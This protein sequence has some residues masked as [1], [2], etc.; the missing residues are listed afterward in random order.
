MEPENAKPVTTVK[1]KRT[2]LSKLLRILAWIIGSVIFLV[3]LVLLL[4]QLPAV[5]NYG[6]KKVVSFLE[7]KL[8]TKVAIGKL[9]IDF[10]TSLS[11]QQ[12][13]FE[14]QAKDTLL[15]GGELKVNLKML[16]LLRNDIS[17]E[18]IYLDNI[19]ANVTRLPPDS[20]FNFQFIV[21]AFSS[22]QV[23]NPET[24][25]TATLKMA[26]DH[27]NVRNSHIVYK[28]AFTGNDMKLSI[29]SL[30]TD[31]DR[32]DPAHMLF[33]IPSI[34]LNGLT[35]HF[36]QLEPLKKSIEKTVNEAAAE[37]DNFLQ[38][39]SKEIALASIDV[40][41][42]NEPSHL[43]TAFKIGSLN[44]QPET[45][46]LK[47][48][49]IRLKEAALKNSHVTIETDS[50][51][52]DEEPKD[53]VITVETTPPFKIIASKINIE[54][55]RLDF[56]DRAAPR[57]P[58]GMD[59]AH[60]HLSDLSLEAS[61]ILYSVDTITA[62]IAG[63]QMRDQSGFVLNEMRTN[64]EMNPTGVSLQNLLIKTPGSHI[65]R[66]ATI[67]YP[68]L[69]ALQ[70][71]PGVLG[72]DIDLANSRISVKDLMTFVP[73]LQ[74]QLTGLSPDASLYADARITG[75]VN[76]MNFRKLVL[77]GLSGTDI[78]VSGL[79][80]GMPVMEKLYT[81]LEIT[82]LQTNATDVNAFLPK[83]TLPANITL[84]RLMSMT[85][86]IR[87]GMQNMY[88]DLAINS[89]LGGAK[90]AGTLANITNEKNARYDLVVNA[91]NLQLK[92]LL[93]NPQLGILTAD[94]AVKGSGISPESANA[95]FNATV[96]LVTLNSYNYRNIRANGSIANKLYKINA[97]VLDPNVSAS[98]Q[99]AGQFEGD[100]P[101]VHVNAVIDSIK[102]LPLH[103]TA[104]DIKYHGNIVADFAS[105]DP[106]NLRG[107][108][109]V[110]NSILVRNGERVTLDS[111]QVIA[112]NDMEQRSLSLRTGFLG[113]TIKGQYTLTQ[114][115]SVFQQ[116]ID[117]YFSITDIKDTVH[118]AP[119]NF[120]LE[121]KA[122]NDPALRVFVPSLTEMKP[123][124]L[125]ANFASDSGWNMQ[126]NAPKIVYGGLQLDD[127]VFDAETSDSGLAFKT[128]LEQLTSN[129]SP[130]LYI[131]GI[132]GVLNNNRADFVLNIKDKE[133][134]DKYRI[135]AFVAQT[136]QEKYQFSLDPG[137]LLLNYDQWKIN[138]GNSIQYAQNYLRAN[139]FVLSQGEQRLSINSTESGAASPLLVDFKNFSIATLSGFI[140]QDS[141]LVNGLLNGNAL[142]KNIM[143]QPEFITDLTVQD[144]SIYNDTIGNLVAKVDN[145]TANTYR[146]Q[147]NLTGR[148]NDIDIS[149]D[150]VVKPGNSQYDILVAIKSFQ[151]K[152]L[153][154][155][156]NGAVRDGRGNLYGTVALKGTMDEPEIDGKIQFNNT[157]F[158]VSMLNNVFRIDNEAI[159]IIDNQGIRLNTFTIR[160]TAENKLVIDG[161]INT[162]NFMDYSFDLDIRANKFQAINSS[163]KDNELFYGKMV[164]TT[165]LKVTGTP[166]SPV[167][168]G[169][170]TINDETNFTVVLPQDEPGIAQREGIVRFVDY[171]ATAEDS[172]FMAAYDS[173]NVSKLIGY[174][175]AVNINVDKEAVFNLIVDAGNGDFLR[176][177]GTAQLTGGIDPSGKVNLVGSYEIDEGSYDLS[178]N[179]IKRKFS[180]QKGSRIVWTGEPTSAQIDVTAIYQA[181]TAPLDLVQGQISGNE[182]IYK[183]KLPFEV[184]LMMKGELM[185]PVIT[186]DIVLPEEK[187]YNVS[188]D[189]ISTV[190]NKLVQLRQESG[191]MNKQVFALLLLNRFVGANP[192]DNSSGGSLDANTFARQSVSKLLTEQLN[193]LAEG[194][195]E[196][197][198]INFD[199]A[200]TEDYTTGSKQNRTDFNVGLSKRLL[201]DRLTVSVGSNFEL[202]GPRR[203]NQQQNNLAGNISINYKLSKDGRYALRAYRKNDYTGALEGYVV[204]TGL[205]FIISVDYNRF[206]EIFLSKESR[207]KKR[208]I[209][210][211]NKELE[212][213]DKARQQ[214]LREE[215]AA[216]LK[217]ESEPINNN[218]D[219]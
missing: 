87:G 100:F 119:Y 167:V 12:V 140:Q 141:L 82:K 198:D 1:K 125:Y 214:K 172:I 83:N 206:R 188:N 170:L 204:E 26:I 39:F 81:D 74:Q 189:I 130:M 75:S 176:L 105:T 16:R 181:N 103:L 137:N 168:D 177:K 53:T 9:D 139:D 205:A 24:E 122:V 120:T 154:G 208:Q 79:V 25:D 146:A 174:D 127:M 104:D 63:A 54:N 124:N 145:K 138:E 216:K 51:Q 184:N 194:L 166:V 37:P 144:L 101:G 49:V 217:S 22:E 197:V 43:N 149:G 89:S 150:Y 215:E 50:K 129:G 182:N 3:L 85:G 33:D 78:Q 213:E 90:I 57:A 179:F 91:R 48:S 77:R 131:T 66:A 59:Y 44:L 70:K 56:D 99:A 132:K 35:G 147:I 118:L 123:V 95:T 28:D 113:A 157:A 191:E 55:S 19:V 11:L 84:P 121:M 5:Q 183:Q 58:N 64:F 142:L 151:M 112:A 126:M 212:K 62:K 211:Q 199:L 97:S 143:T 72:L 164:F 4:I 185:K 6:R 135:G 86:K 111:I 23:K 107:N 102:T 30:E 159:A 209:R 34:R 162:K 161:D 42:K 207:R 41:Y 155:L 32:F 94:V 15:Y 36:F 10:P 200:T 31:I 180:I 106:D 38:F 61:D 115:G 47:N 52:A 76:N 171:S 163:K 40:Q 173:L 7:N 21:D 218:K 134:K 169:D 60:L 29:G 133:E 65:Q 109:A 108:M 27:I 14:D 68:S 178:F 110:T 196:G 114:L 93:Q 67:T 156:T 128:S 46:D 117:P 210:R 219:E 190:Q 203:T 88:T 17:I 20:V 195:I 116:A 8:H 152:S 175:V 96:P 13:Y 136:G 202:E 201:N 80:K 45:F 160:D 193:S 186:F 153:E 18:E 69:D 192:F 187:N 165:R 92:T 148:G 158:N 98:L 71:D 2:V 73:A